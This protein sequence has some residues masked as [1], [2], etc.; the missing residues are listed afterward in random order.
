MKIPFLSNPVLPSTGQ[1]ADAK[2]LGKHT[3]NTGCERP[4][5]SRTI[6]RCQGKRSPV[7]H[8][9]LLSPSH[10]ACLTGDRT[11]QGSSAGCDLAPSLA[12]FKPKVTFIPGMTG[13]SVVPSACPWRYRHGDKA[14]VR[15]KLT[16]SPKHLLVACLS[17]KTCVFIRNA[18]VKTHDAPRAFP[19]STASGSGCPIWGII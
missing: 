3:E 7:S 18:A 13:E 4:C 12:C 10:K 16:N 5:R 14:W 11:R 2:R 6:C 17:A 8:A 9:R 19:A 1:G 15:T